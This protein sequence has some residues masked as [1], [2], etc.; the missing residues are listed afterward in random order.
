MEQVCSVNQERGFLVGRGSFGRV[1][2][3]LDDESGML[4]AVK[5]LRGSGGNRDKQLKKE[6]AVMKKLKHRNVVSFLGSS[7]S[8]EGRVLI[9]Q[10]WIPGGRNHAIIY[11]AFKMN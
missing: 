10:E 6:I 8:K 4:V 11:A 9:Y 2:V 1:Y 7:V 5:E 3:T